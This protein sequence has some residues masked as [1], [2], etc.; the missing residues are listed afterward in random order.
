MNNEVSKFADTTEQFRISKKKKNP[1]DIM[2]F[3]VNKHVY[4][5][6]IILILHIDLMSF[7]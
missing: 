6:G 7:S 5:E 1:T 4:G 2:Q 3:N